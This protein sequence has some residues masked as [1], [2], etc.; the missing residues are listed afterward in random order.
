ME[1]KIPEPVITIKVNYSDDWS[2][3]N[4]PTVYWGEVIGLDDVLLWKSEEYSSEEW[5]YE[6]AEDRAKGAAIEHVN[7][8]LKG[9]LAA[10]L[11][12]N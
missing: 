12:G 11:K 3:P 4:M 5:G 6:G 8:A 9:L 10:G 1:I 7:A 2:R